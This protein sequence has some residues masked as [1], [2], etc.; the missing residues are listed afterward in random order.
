MRTHAIIATTV[1]AVTALETGAFTLVHPGQRTN[2]GD[3]AHRVN[4]ACKAPY[5][6]TDWMIRNDHGQKVDGYVTVT[7]RKLGT[8]NI[9]LDEYEVV[10]QR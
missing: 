2:G 5:R 6:V 9:T 10:L 4:S 1:A 7:C 8:Y 3:L